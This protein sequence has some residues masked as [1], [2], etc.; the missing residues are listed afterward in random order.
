[1]RKGTKSQKE[2]KRQRAIID[3]ELLDEFEFGA[4]EES[5]SVEV[6]VIVDFESA[7]KMKE[8]FDKIGKKAKK[9]PAEDVITEL[10]YDDI[11]DAIEIEEA[12]LEK[13]IKEAGVDVNTAKSKTTGKTDVAALAFVDSVSIRLPKFLIYSI[14]EP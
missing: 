5:D 2:K 9:A 4:Y 7:E 8:F 3:E 10:S 1:M 11:V 12:V 13:S 6:D 14:A